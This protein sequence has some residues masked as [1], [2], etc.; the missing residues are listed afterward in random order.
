MDEVTG[1]VLDSQAFDTYGSS[2]AGHAFNNYLD[3][4]EN[5]RVV[6]VAT[7]DSADKHSKWSDY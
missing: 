7:Q 3:A 1:K 4:I 5:G 6:V 2:K